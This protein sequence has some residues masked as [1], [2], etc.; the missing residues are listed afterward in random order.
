MAKTTPATNTR[1]FTGPD[2]VT[3]VTLDCDGH[4]RSKFRA[5]LYSG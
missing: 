1:D 5:F 2:G 4:N 3:Y